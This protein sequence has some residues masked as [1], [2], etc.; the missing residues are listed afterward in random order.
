[1]LADSHEFDLVWKDAAPLLSKAIEYS[2]GKETI[3]N[4]YQRVRARDMQLWV[5]FSYEMEAALVT[6]ID[7][8]PAKKVLSIPY[9]GGTGADRW[10]DNLGIIEDFAKAQGC[11]AVEIMGRKGWQKL[12]PDYDPIHVVIRKVL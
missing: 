7:Q 5:V 2:D 10:L 4:L 8:H 3:E 9:L 6:R 12:L 1:M 11:E